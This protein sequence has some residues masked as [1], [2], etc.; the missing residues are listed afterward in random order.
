RAARKEDEE[1]RQQWRSLHGWKACVTRVGSAAFNVDADARRDKPDGRRPGSR[2]PGI[3]AEGEVAAGASLEGVGGPLELLDR[4]PILSRPPRGVP[5]RVQERPYLVGLQVDVGLRG[6]FVAPGLD[7]EVDEIRLARYLPDVA[8]LLEEF[9]GDLYV[10]V[11]RVDQAADLAVRGLGTLTAE[12]TA[13]G[14]GVAALVSFHHAR[15]QLA[16]VG[17]NPQDYRDRSHGDSHWHTPS[18]IRAARPRGK[19]DAAGKDA[20]DRMDRQPRG[21]PDEILPYRRPGRRRGH[22]ARR[23]RAEE[24]PVDA[25]RGSDAPCADPPGRA[26]LR[27]DAARAWRAG[28]TRPRGT[29]VLAGDRDRF[30]APERLRAAGRDAERHHVPLAGVGPGAVRPPV[31]ASARKRGELGAAPRR[32]LSAAQAYGTHGPT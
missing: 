3:E 15:E 12:A 18:G 4:L 13:E 11:E 8:G 16:D 28:G 19:G 5:D 7:H 1:S 25:P 26:A 9:V 21:D 22:D 30:P 6:L 14:L 2:S 24:V 32:V 17:V 23:M 10:R 31:R 27:A 29:G 20:A